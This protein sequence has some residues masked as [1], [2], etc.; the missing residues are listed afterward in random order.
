MSNNKSSLQSEIG[1][2][3][4][5]LRDYRINASVNKSASFVAGRSFAV[6][7]LAL[8]GGV[9]ITTIENRMGEL[10]ELISAYRGRPTPVRLRKLPLSIEIPHSALEP[11][12]PTWA[13]LDLPAHTLLLG[14]S[15]GYG[16]ASDET[17]SLVDSPHLLVAGT[18]GSGKSRLLEL[19]IYSLAL[20]TSP[21]DLR[22]VFVDMK[23]EDLVQFRALPHC[24]ALALS[25]PDAVQAVC[26]VWHAKEQRVKS[27]QGKYQRLVL[28]IDE[29]AELS[30]SAEIMGW[31]ASILA[32]GRSKNINVI[33]ATQKP[34]AKVVGSV[35]KANFTTRLV[36]KVLGANDAEVAAGMPG[37]GA[38]LLPGKG[39]FLHIRGDQQQ[40]FQS[41]LLDD[42]AD[43]AHLRT[44]Q[45]GV[46]LSEVQQV[47]RDRWVEQLPLPLAETKEVKGQ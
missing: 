46:K 11:L 35:A 31:L 3:E 33:A 1:L 26:D 5:F 47:I 45:G 22:M 10:S 32:I 37:T 39:S 17:I 16:G 42:A 41:Y 8:G 44:E 6:L 25:L 19:L 43:L 20:N 9:R 15:Y 23:N 34:T 4:K 21:A 40:R 36:G 18:T 2:I 13:S 7:G 38:H 14:K 29:L 27:G 28:I 12:F 30:R 24:E